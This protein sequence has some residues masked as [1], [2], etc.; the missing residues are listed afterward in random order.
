MEKGQAERVLNDRFIYPVAIPILG[1]LYR[2][3]GES[4]TLIQ[5]LRTPLYYLDLSVNI[6][7]TALLWF[8]NRWIILKLIRE[9][10]A[11]DQ[12]F[13]RLVLQVMLGILPS[14]LFII[15]ISFFYNDILIDRPSVFSLAL[16]FTFDIPVGFLMLV[17]IHL[18]YLCLYLWNLAEGAPIA[19]GVAATGATKPDMNGKRSLLAHVG[20]SMKP[21]SLDEISY[22]FKVDEFTMVRTNDGQDY[23]VEYTLEN[24][25]D[26]LPPDRFFRINRQIIGSWDSIHFVRH[27]PQTGKLIVE[28]KPT[29]QQPVS[30][31]RKKA[32]EFKAWMAK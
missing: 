5:L 20:K 17:I 14:I 13:R 8:F 12:L 32:V 18:I 26:E 9:Y 1:I 3:I 23:R 22:I 2:H 10:P 11:Q 15:L 27:D 19:E 30:V 25:I 31:S 28:L 6:L 4:A 24:L 29:F 21:V 7:I 16:V